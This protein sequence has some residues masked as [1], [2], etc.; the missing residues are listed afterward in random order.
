MTRPTKQTAVWAR[1]SLIFL[2]VL[3]L[4]PLPYLMALTWGEY[5]RLLLITVGLGCLIWRY[6]RVREERPE[7]RISMMWRL[8][9]RR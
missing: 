9:V 8:W 5:V 3:V 4:Q 7:G 6:S 2:G 1:A